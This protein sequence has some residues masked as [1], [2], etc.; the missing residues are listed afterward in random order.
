MDLLTQAVLGS[1]LA[2]SGSRK[3]ETRLATVIGCL[4]GLLADSDALIRSSSDSLLTI[5]YHRHFTHS[6]FFVPF[7]ALI[8]AF[9]L[10]PFLKSKIDFKRLYWFSFLGYSLSGFIDACTSYGTYLFWPIV[11]ERISFYLI[12]IVDPVFTIALITGVIVAYK[13]LQPR[14]ALA[15]LAFAALYLSISFIQLQRAQSAIEQVAI[16]RGHT[17]EDIITKPT[18]ANIILWRS[19][20]K[21]QGNIYID[22]VRVGYETRVYQGSSVKQFDIERDAA[23]IDGK[24]ILYDDIKRFNK[25]SDGYISI[26]PD[27]DHIIGDARYSFQADGVR[28]LWGIDFNFDKPDEHAVFRMY[29]EYEKNDLKR[30]FAMLKNQDVAQ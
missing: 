7:G 23:S 20:Y 5:E 19:T 18:M 28:P 2:Q 16:E 29:H 21:N 22:A 15:G 10:W 27:D 24:S 1:A 8:A 30:F 3:T 17:P 26:H 12:A 25:F 4:S 11:D 14:A 9:I 13:K 6:I